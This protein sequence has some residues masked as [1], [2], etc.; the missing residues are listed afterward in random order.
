M[1]NFR[2]NVFFT[3]ITGIRTLVTNYRYMDA[4]QYVHV[5]VTLLI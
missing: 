3:N 4:G 5:D 1:L 2:L